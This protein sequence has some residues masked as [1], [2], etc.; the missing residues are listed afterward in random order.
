[1]TALWLGMPMTLDAW[2]TMGS[3]AGAGVGARIGN[4]WLG[5]TAPAAWAPGSACGAG[6]SRAPVAIS[7]FAAGV[8][9]AASVAGSCW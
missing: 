3:A 5:C 8:A 1:M 2:G 9:A 4:G 6:L 7:G